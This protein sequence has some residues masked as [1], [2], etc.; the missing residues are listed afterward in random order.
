M[1]LFDRLYL[2]IIFFVLFFSNFFLLCQIQP[3]FPYGE[4]SA[5]ISSHLHFCSIF[6]AD[7]ISVGMQFSPLSYNNNILVSPYYYVVPT[8]HLSSALSGYDS[9]K[10]Y[11]VPCMLFFDD[12]TNV[13]TIAPVQPFSH[14][15]S[16]T[17]VFNNFPLLEPDIKENSGYKKI[18]VN[19]VFTNYIHTIDNPLSILDVSFQRTGN[20]VWNID[21]D[22]DL[23]FSRPIFP[24]FAV[25]D[26][27]FS[28]IKIGES[29]TDTNGILHYDLI[30]IPVTVNLSSDGLSVTLT[31][32]DSFEPGS[33]YFLKVN[34]E[35]YLGDDFFNTSYN[36]TVPDRLI[37]DIEVHF[38]NN[39]PV[40]E[41]KY[42]GYDGQKLY[43]YGDTV[44]IGFPA[45][46]GDYYLSEWR[47]PES[48]EGMLYNYGEFLELI[49][50]ENNYFSNAQCNPVFNSI[51]KS[52][53]TIDVYYTENPVDTL[54]LNFVIDSLLSLAYPGYS[55]H[56]LVTGIEDKLDDSTYTYRR[57]SVD[58]VFIFYDFGDTL[59]ASYWDVSAS[60]FVQSA[61]I[62]LSSSLVFP[63]S[64]V[65]TSAVADPGVGQTNRDTII[66]IT[67]ENLDIV[68]E[69]AACE[70][71]LFKVELNYMGYESILA[72]TFE[73]NL[74]NIVDM[75][76]EIVLINDRGNEFYP[77]F[78]PFTLNDSITPNSN[79]V[80]G[81]VQITN[82]PRPDLYKPIVAG[83]RVVLSNSDYEIF[84]VTTKYGPAKCTVDNDIVRRANYGTYNNEIIY[85]NYT[86][87]G[88]SGVSGK[89]YTR[90][91]S[92][93]GNIL[94]IYIRRKIVEF[95]FDYRALEKQNGVYKECNFPGVSCTRLDFNEPS[96]VYIMKRYLPQTLF[97]LEDKYGN[98]DYSWLCFTGKDAEVRGY[99]SDDIWGFN[100]HRRATRL[101]A[102]LAPNKV[103]TERVSVFYYSGE[104]FAYR[105]YIK[106]GCGFKV[107]R[108]TLPQ[109]STYIYDP[110]PLTNPDGIV[111]V[112]KFRS[113]ELLS[114]DME[115]G[116]VLK[117]IEV[118]QLIEGGGGWEYKKYAVDDYH[119][120]V[121]KI[122]IW[123]DGILDDYDNGLYLN[124]Q[125]DVSNHLHT[126][127]VL[128]I[129]QFNKDV[130]P[131]S[132][133][134]I[135]IEDFPDY[136]PKNE[137]R[138]DSNNYGSYP[139][140][141]GG[142]HIW[143]G[144]V[145]RYSIMLVN[146][147]I[148][149][150]KNG[151]HK[152]CNLQKF[153]IDITNTKL[154]PI[155]AYDAWEESYLEDIL[156]NIVGRKVFRAS[157]LPPGLESRLKS[158]NNISE[159][160]D[161]FHGTDIEVYIHLLTELNLLDRANPLDG[162]I[163]TRDSVGRLEF[164]A[165]M[166]RFPGTDYYEM[167]T[168]KKSSVPESYDLAEVDILHSEHRILH[169]FHWADDQGSSSCKKIIDGVTEA[170]KLGL[171][172]AGVSDIDI[173][174]DTAKGI[175]KDW[176][177]SG[178]RYLNSNN[179][180][181]VRGGKTTGKV[182]DKNSQYKYS[183]YILLPDGHEEETWNLYYKQ[184]WGIW[185]CGT[186][187][188]YSPPRERC[189]YNIVLDFKNL[190]PCNC[191][192]G[193]LVNGVP[194]SRFKPIFSFAPTFFTTIEVWTGN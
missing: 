81:N 32:I 190:E 156:C 121:Y 69:P 39:V 13:I 183:N 131:V 88:E 165:K 86:L 43:Y 187:G 182:I 33:S 9:M 55:E 11:S 192:G 21:E 133:D 191:G 54:H 151:T 19:A 107:A 102:S 158:F 51:K 93:C 38:P 29:T 52:G 188:M 194:S 163:P 59:T 8:V 175:F 3:L 16:Y 76:S 57:Y 53:I 61:N 141:W 106:E 74:A 60:A 128:L 177:C 103:L 119:A 72:R 172:L 28:I 118:P 115:E 95:A 122:P 87:N 14:N 185:G 22:I 109:N 15:I 171:K 5:S 114:G 189:A 27:M 135:K 111:K 82:Y 104:D 79:K 136:L 66:I 130:Y 37:V 137:L 166:K 168:S 152:M 25:L 138:P 46:Y 24:N 83:Y 181:L 85:Q 176:I 70:Y 178:D 31:H 110:S 160:D 44:R 170:T 2:F 146:N 94:K 134:N 144:G 42:R 139:I 75:I 162:V 167:D 36:F 153:N 63:A 62:T 68:E 100:Y 89:I 98:I 117:Y 6:P 186:Y 7:E 17:V 143:S 23:Y 64:A 20:V 113:A 140:I 180:W 56:F 90:N 173:V 174:I 124:E 4:T 169:S 48:T 105:P 92:A 164:G 101:D 155:L 50:D 123:V 161:F 30:T 120:D 73:K 67:F 147:A 149:P 148:T 112:T 80:S 132:F 97:P 45:F 78:T 142:N 26:S 12:S 99:C 126:N 34:W 127:T 179:F 71:G 108:L 150:N 10:L 18:F 125:W 58:S 91:D 159:V 47:L 41:F 84:L 154:N 77:V 129:F 184:D 35:Y 1:K 157:T 40:G 116:F 145:G 49:L 65:L 96:P 193:Y